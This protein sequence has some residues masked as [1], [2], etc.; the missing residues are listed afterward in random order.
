M[1]SWRFF[2]FVSLIYTYRI[3]RY[4]RSETM[5]SSSFV[6]V[7]LAQSQD[8][9]NSKQNKNITLY[10]LQSI[11]IN[12]ILFTFYN[13]PEVKLLLSPFYEWDIPSCPRSS[14]YS[15]VNLGLE[16][17]LT[18][19]VQVSFYYSS[20]SACILISAAIFPL[21]DPSSP[22]KS[23]QEAWKR[24]EDKPFLL[25]HF[26][27]PFQYTLLYLG[28]FSFFFFNLSSINLFWLYMQQNFIVCNI[29]IF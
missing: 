11:F 12:V 6:S 2:M 28:F 1:L 15:V 18:A 23:Q 9:P 20:Y 26:S 21:F 24:T 17:L 16:L 4:L 8:Y 29:M 19:Q 10:N 5:F 25:H 7:T 3:I 22:S 14:W 27:S 13:N